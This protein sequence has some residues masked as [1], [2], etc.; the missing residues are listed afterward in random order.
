MKK[1]SV[2]MILFFAF[3]GFVLNALESETSALNSF[4][5]PRFDIGYSAGQSIGNRQGYAEVGLFT[6]IY[7][8]DSCL[9]LVECRGYRFNNS[10]WGLSSS[11]SFRNKIKN[12]PIVGANVYY[13][14]LQGKFNKIF[15]RLGLGLEWFGECLD[16]R[17]NAYVPLGLQKHYS[18]GVIFTKECCDYKWNG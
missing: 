6:P 16:F 11:F 1:L 17:F 18:N 12:G 4:L 8:K 15:N 13:D 7:L 3:R 9:S 14:N 2:F 5:Q 10:K